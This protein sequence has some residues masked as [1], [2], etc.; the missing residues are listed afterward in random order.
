MNRRL[1]V[2]IL[3]KHIRLSMF[4]SRNIKRYI[5]EVTERLNKFKVYG[6]PQ[7][8]KAF[9]LFCRSLGLFLP[10]KKKGS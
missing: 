1:A 6:V 5:R 2:R 3:R 8:P 7:D 4:G 9:L 10:K